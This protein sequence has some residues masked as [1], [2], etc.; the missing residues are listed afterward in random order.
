MISLVNLIDTPIRFYEQK[1]KLFTDTNDK[2]KI[3]FPFLKRVEA[4]SIAL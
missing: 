3:Q 4:I 2:L 1:E